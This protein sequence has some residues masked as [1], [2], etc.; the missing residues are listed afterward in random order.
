MLKIVTTKVLTKSPQVEQDVGA[1]SI[2]QCVTTLVK[3]QLKV[4][5]IKELDVPCNVWTREG[6]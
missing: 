6:H 2:F 4:D 5:T 3:C 1:W